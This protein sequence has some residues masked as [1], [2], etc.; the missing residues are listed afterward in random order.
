MHASASRFRLADTNKHISGHFIIC[1][2][3][4]A[5]TQPVSRAPK[6]NETQPSGQNLATSQQLYVI[7][8]NIG[9]L[10]GAYAS[11]QLLDIVP[12]GD[13]Y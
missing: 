9:Q 2:R 7:I 5:P 4:Q 1:E 3:L 11:K 10:N 8:G 12:F 6:T 13:H